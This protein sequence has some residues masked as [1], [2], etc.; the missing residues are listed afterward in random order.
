[1]AVFFGFHMPNYT[2]P[3]VPDD[4]LFDHLVKQAQAAE[5]A[6]FDLITVMDHFYQIRGVGPETNAMLEAYATLAGLA[7]NTSRVKLG[8]LV[9]GVTYRNPALLVKQ[10]TTLDVIS[11]GARS[12]GSA[13]R[14]TRTSMWVTGSSSR[15]SRAAWI[16]SMR[17]CRS[18]S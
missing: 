6:G 3:G 12:S 1:M 7:A 11:K 13:L 5:A 17:P 15:R 9:T 4:K 14:G 10:V 16:A 2:F 8:T 18:R